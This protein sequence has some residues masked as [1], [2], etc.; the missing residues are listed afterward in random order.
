MGTTIER[1]VDEGS[2]VETVVTALADA[3]GVAVRD[4]DTPLYD[5]VDTDALERI[6]EPSERGRMRVG[7]RVIFSVDGYEI[8]VHGTGRVAVT[9]IVEADSRGV[10][11][12]S[13]G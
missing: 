8:V 7:G 11:V 10:A 5:V 9:P 1:T 6:F 13:N 12:G 3:K 4:I 2:V